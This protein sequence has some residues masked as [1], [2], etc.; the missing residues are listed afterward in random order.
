[1]SSST[2]RSA[3][4]NI[5]DAD[6]MPLQVFTS[7]EFFA[8]GF[9]IENMPTSIYFGYAES[10]R[11][12]S[13]SSGSSGGCSSVSGFVLLVLAGLLLFRRRAVVFALC[14]VILAAPCSW[15]GGLST[16]DYTLPISQDN[17]TPAGT[18]TTN[19]TL[20]QEMVSIIAQI[21][22]VSADKVH[23]FSELALT[24]WQTM[25]ADIYNL[26]K[27]GEYGG[28]TLPA[29]DSPETGNYYVLLCTF[30]NDVKP[31]ELMGT[32]GFE[33]SADTRRSVYRES[34]YYSSVHWVALNDA[35]EVIDSVPENR[36]VYLAVSYRPEY[37]NAGILTVIRGEYVTENDP[38]DRLDPGLAQI[39]ADEV[40]ID[41]SELKFLSR[42]NIGDP[43]PPTQDMIAYVK[44][45]DHEIIDGI[46][47]IS[48]D[49]GGWY[50]FK[51]RL[52]DTIWDEVQ[53]RQISDYKFYG[54]NDDRSEVSASF[55][56]GLINTWELFTLTGNK[57]NSFGVREFVMVVLLNAGRPLSLYLA[58]LLIMLLLGGCN[59][60]VT[61][62]VMITAVIAGVIALRFTKKR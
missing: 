53:G 32:A 56:T 15:A 45:D 49:Q 10:E 24:E 5:L 51:V 25:P 1:M 50:A 40:G 18:W 35:Y 47:T 30:S 61:A 7:K 20:T 44:S 2:V 6:G 23:S 57:M 21:G 8:S 38:L 11:E 26:A 48:V 12:Y 17:Y 16:S 14:L 36:R 29:A 3:S 13:A 31:G 33:V 27:T 37:I 52:S 22:G 34:E 4:W 59:T 55:I 28:V 46:N 39:I 60:G 62:S 19:F 41:V 42:A 9:M 58:K 43:V 54:L